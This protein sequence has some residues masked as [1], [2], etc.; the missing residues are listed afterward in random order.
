MILLWTGRLGVFLFTRILGAGGDNRF[1]EIK[2]SKLYFFVTWMSQGMWVV[3]TSGPLLVLMTKK[4]IST[5]I[6][7]L[8]IIGIV[9]WAFGLVF[10]AIAD[11]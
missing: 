7:V 8:E 6:Q 1:D 4:D 10:E 3:V 2:K 11:Y 5:S 9:I